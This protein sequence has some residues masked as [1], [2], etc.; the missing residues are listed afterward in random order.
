VV[1]ATPSLRQVS[2]LKP[3]RGGSTVSSQL[4]VQQPRPEPE[5]HVSPVGRQSRLPRSIWHCPPRQRFEQH[6]ALAAHDSLSTLHSPP[7]HRPPKQPSE[8]QSSAFPQGA[9]SAKQKPVHS[10]TPAMPVTGAQWPLQ[11]APF[12]L[13]AIPGAWHCPATASAQTPPAQRPEQQLAALVQAVLFPVQP[14]CAAQVPDWQ[15]PEQQSAPP[16]HDAPL[17]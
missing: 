8:Q 10:T 17:A 1:H 15:R 5:L 11:Q 12:A 7:P 9:P 2:L 4:S 14:G 3:Q 6:S 13:H 16:A